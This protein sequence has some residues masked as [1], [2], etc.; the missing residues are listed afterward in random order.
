M[1]KTEKKFAFGFAGFAA[2]ALLVAFSFLSVGT[3]SEA[4]GSVNE[5]SLYG[6]AAVFKD[7]SLAETNPLLEAT[8]GQP[9]RIT[10]TNV[11]EGV[12]HEIS[13][14]ELGVSNTKVKWGNEAV[15]DF[16]PEVEGTYEYICERHKG[17]MKGK[18]HI[19]AAPKIQ[20][21]TASTAQAA[22]LP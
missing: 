21:L 5:I 18:I 17:L 13:I 8:V 6:H 4:Q 22:E 3:T 9:V 1:S 20:V 12:V 2:I 15:I 16:V 11:D 7:A 10:F 14:P 19:S